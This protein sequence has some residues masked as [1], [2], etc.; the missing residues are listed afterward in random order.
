MT[1]KDGSRN[2][3]HTAIV[4]AVAIICVAVASWFYIQQMDISLSGKGYKNT[5]FTDA[6]LLC[7]KTAKERF[8]SNLKRITLDSHSSRYDHSIGRYKIF[9]TATISRTLRKK[10]AKPEQVP[11]FLVCSVSGRSGK[12]RDF[13]ALEDKSDKPEAQRK[14]KGSLFGWP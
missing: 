6:L 10:G 9:F 5:T 11:F 14:D 13:D 8:G 4:M 3:S 1:R 2:N 12:L 7:Q